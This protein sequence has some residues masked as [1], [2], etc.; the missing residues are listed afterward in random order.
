MVVIGHGTGRRGLPHIPRCQ[1]VSTQSRFTLELRREDARTSCSPWATPRGQEQNGFSSPPRAPGG[2]GGA[3][4]A[5]DQLRHVAQA[6][7]RPGAVLAQCQR[8]RDLCR[9]QR[10]G[11]RHPI[12]LGR[13]QLRVQRRAGPELE[14]QI[15]RLV[16]DLHLCR[17]V[18]H[19]VQDTTEA[20]RT[21]C[22]SAT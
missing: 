6:G 5:R 13:L 20:A 14:A 21:P 2:L 22:S 11:P 9:A 19:A 10:A 4:P 12:R 16:C 7:Q 17:T 15:A 8:R 18:R 3:R 1:R